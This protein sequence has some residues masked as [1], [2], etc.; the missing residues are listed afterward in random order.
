MC[1]VC[2][3]A[4]LSEHRLETPDTTWDR[5]QHGTWCFP[6]TPS[7]CHY[8]SALGALANR[9]GVHPV[10]KWIESGHPQYTY[11]PCTA[12]AVST[13]THQTR[14][15][16]STHH[17][18]LTVLNEKLAHEHSTTHTKRTCQPKHLAPPPP[19]HTHH[20]HHHHHP[21]TQ[22]VNPRASKTTHNE[23]D[24]DFVINSAQ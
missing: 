11:V 20:H 2:L 14:E 18:Q 3:L 7:Q 17:H 12:R 19:Q 22:L 1:H 13:M 24:A 15:S 5:R 8:W 23:Q 9:I 10:R 4:W 6:T 21:P 16:T